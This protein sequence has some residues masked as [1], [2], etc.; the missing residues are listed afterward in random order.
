M[1]APDLA[2]DIASEVAKTAPPALVIGA[3]VGGWGPQEWMYTLTACYV[4][5]QSVYLL[6][7]WRRE[8]RRKSD[9]EYPDDASGI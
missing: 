9:A 8:A 2:N 4:V 1:H 7:K 6:W 3:T 5:L